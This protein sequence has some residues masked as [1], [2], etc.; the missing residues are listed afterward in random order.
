VSTNYI[1][2][3][4]LDNKVFLIVINARYKREDVL[5]NLFEQNISNL[6]PLFFFVDLLYLIK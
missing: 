1:F 5:Q 6:F 2:V 4:L 3:H